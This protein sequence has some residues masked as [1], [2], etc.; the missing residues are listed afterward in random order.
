M[1]IDAG[2]SESCINLKGAGRGVTG[3]TPQAYAQTIANN[4]LLWTSATQSERRGIYVRS[5]NILIKGNYIEN[6]SYGIY[7]AQEAQTDKRVSI[8][9][10]YL[11]N[12][13]TWG[14]YLTNIGGDALF[15]KNNIIENITSS[16]GTAYPIRVEIA[17]ATDLVQIVD[18]TIRVDDSCTTTGEVRSIQVGATAATLGKVII[19]R[20]TIDI[21]N[22]TAVHTA[23]KLT[24][25]ADISKAIITDNTIP[26]IPGTDHR[27][28]AKYISYATKPAAYFA[29]NN[30]LALDETNILERF[31]TVERVFTYDFNYDPN[32]T[33]VLGYIPENAVI[34]RV[35]YNVRIQPVAGASA[36]MAL[37]I[38]TDDTAGLKAAVVVTDASWAAGWHDGI[39]D[40]LAAN[41]SNTTTD[42]RHIDALLVGADLTA[43]LVDVYITYVMVP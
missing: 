13:E 40:G 41:Y 43:G 34:T 36:S 14:I 35:A 1:I 29:R 22:T 32:G 8:I 12:T 16:G 24:G 9:G 30:G 21:I 42:I 39:Q 19:E 5:D 33:V 26:I 4:I 31:F 27:H 11:K 28:Y 37:S 38:H 15:V 23:I 20:N 3:G 10:N 17:S 6:A 2:Y 25:T 7:A 18:N